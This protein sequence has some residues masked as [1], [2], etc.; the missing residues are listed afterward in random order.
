MV[1]VNIYNLDATSPI[2]CQ[3][4]VGTYYS[5]RPSARPLIDYVP[6]IT[7]G[8]QFVCTI[9]IS[10]DGALSPVFIPFSLD[11]SLP[12]HRFLLAVDRASDVRFIS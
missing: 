10:E 3:V 7:M 8:S 6:K 4:C 11:L 2:N 1:A 9:P 12:N 5:S